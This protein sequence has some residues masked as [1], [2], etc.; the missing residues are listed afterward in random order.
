METSGLSICTNALAVLAGPN[1]W[2]A[3]KGPNSGRPLSLAARAAGPRLSEQ[4]LGAIGWTI[5][6]TR[7][8][9]GL[10]REGASRHPAGTLGAMVYGT[11][12]FP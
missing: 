2:L 8:C 11:L 5:F 6:G 7:R 9:P 12:R 4:P 3:P 1:H 10:A